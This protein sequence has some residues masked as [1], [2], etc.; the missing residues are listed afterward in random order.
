MY[1]CVMP[2]DEKK[3]RSGSTFTYAERKA[4]GRPLSTFSLSSET[5]IILNELAETLKLSRSAV[6]E[7]AVRELQKKHR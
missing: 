5:K 2:K 4:R 1:S 6:V 3:S 7:L